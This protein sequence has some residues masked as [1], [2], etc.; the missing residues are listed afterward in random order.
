M[1]Q[2]VLHRS[3][4]GTPAPSLPE[5][6]LPCFGA[7]LQA[8]GLGLAFLDREL[9]FRF[10]SNALITLSGLPGT[11]Y[12]GRTTG[13]VW[14]GLAAGLVPLLN[15]AIQGETVV[16]ARVSGP[17][18]THGPRHFR[19]SVLPASTGG[20]R[21]GVG[22]TLEDETERVEQEQALRESEE[23]LRGL[24]AV[25]CDGFMLHDAG[26]I[27]DV[28]AGLAGLFGCTREEMLGQQLMRWVAPE[29]RETVQRSLARQVESPYE[30]TGMR[31]DG[32]RLFLEVLGRQV[33]YAGRPV[34]MT[35]VWDISARKA[36]E[37][38]ASRADVFREQL[39]GVVGHDLRSPLY[40]IQLS[41][42][43]LQRA[44]DL[45]DTQARQVTHVATAARRMERMIHELLDYTRARL[46]GGIPVRPSALALDKQLERVVEQ[47]QVSHP[48]RLIV[49]K[50]E[51]DTR[52][53]WDESRLGQLLDNLVGNAVQHS[54]EDTPVEVKL[55]GASDGITLMVRN[56]GPPVP[57]EE[58]STLFEPFKRG[59]RATG[60]G[61]GLGLYIARQIVMAHGGRISVE[62]GVGLGTR[63]IVWLPRHAP[64][65]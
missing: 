34:R 61:L 22:L 28:S 36:S 60:D 8:T 43:A 58:R 54:P 37:E 15:R 24:V 5:E 47:F 29:S 46:A 65:A 55:T 57:L 7:L 32:K 2:P 45:N 35:A 17:M 51:G 21:S 64:G 10:V 40:A 41:V 3:H 12:E 44:G 16:G 62:S 59:K 23:R 13:E 18:G 33:E 25:S 26:V 1:A 20:L 9:R 50:A 63:F 42:G 4:V 19:V 52:G 39:L 53:S 48:T 27:L 30:L 14:P 11:S 6:A 49:A 38:A 31:G 56:D